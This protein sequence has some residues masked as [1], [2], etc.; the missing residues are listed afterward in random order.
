MENLLTEA[1][2]NAISEDKKGVLVRLMAIFSAMDLCGSFLTGKSNPKPARYNF[3]VFC[4][5]VY[6]PK[7]YHGLSDL[8]YSI[9]RN[10]I[11]HSYVP[12]GFAIPFGPPTSP[13]FHLQFSNDGL[14]LC[15]PKMEEDFGGGLKKLVKNIKRYPKLRK[16]YSKVLTELKQF[17]D[18]KYQEFAR[19]HNIRLKDIPVQA[20]IDIS[21]R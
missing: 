19:L 16:N 1:L 5:S 13:K 17:G 4:K 9:F 3:I 6:M 21:V 10:G 11:M 15:V 20:D 12:K 2:P 7:K 14:W 8:L 18:T